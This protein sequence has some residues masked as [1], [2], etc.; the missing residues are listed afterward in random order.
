MA[1]RRALV[2]SWTLLVA[3]RYEVVSMVRKT[4]LF[5]AASDVSIVI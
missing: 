2:C 1:V 5:N 4:G 3:G